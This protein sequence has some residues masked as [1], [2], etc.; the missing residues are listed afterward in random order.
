VRYASRAAWDPLLAAGIELYEFMPTMFHCKVMIVD[1]QWVSVGSANFD[2]RSFRLNYEANLN[3]F[4]KP[5]AQELTQ[6]FAADIQRSRKFVRRLWRQRS[7]GKRT[8]EW[9]AARLGSQL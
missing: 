2:M 8:V 4:S 3:V 6:Q 5:L 9:L 7:F 1:E